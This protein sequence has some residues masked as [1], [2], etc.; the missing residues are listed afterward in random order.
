MISNHNMKYS[1]TFTKLKD[2]R[3]DEKNMSTAIFSFSALISACFLFRHVSNIVLKRM[4][5][6]ILLVG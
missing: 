1:K 4:L 2:L 5:T 6:K 3:E